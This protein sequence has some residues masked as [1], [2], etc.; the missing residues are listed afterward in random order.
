MPSRSDR[1]GLVEE[2]TVPLLRIINKIEHAG[3]CRVTT[4]L[5]ST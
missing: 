3:V 1:D 2:I 4:E 5:T